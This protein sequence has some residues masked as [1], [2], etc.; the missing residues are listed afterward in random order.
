MAAVRACHAW[1]APSLAKSGTPPSLAKSGTPRHSFRYRLHYTPAR[2]SLDRLL[3]VHSLARRLRNPTRC[4]ETNRACRVRPAR[5]APNGDWR[6]PADIAGAR[7][8]WLPTWHVFVPVGGL[9]TGLWFL[10]WACEIPFD[11]Y[12]ARDPRPK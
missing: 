10:V 6:G 3:H 7:R 9:P 5:L 11:D 4:A 1:P 2:H 8:G 12:N